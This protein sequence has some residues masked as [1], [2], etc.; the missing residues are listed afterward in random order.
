MKNANVVLIDHHQQKHQRD[1][2]AHFPAYTGDPGSKFAVGKGLQWHR[3]TTAEVVKEMV[4]AAVGERVLSEDERARVNTGLRG[5]PRERGLGDGRRTAS[6]RGRG[7]R[8]RGSARECR[9]RW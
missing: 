4:E 1:Q 3:T 2:I 9:H 6:G 8:P 7:V 5:R